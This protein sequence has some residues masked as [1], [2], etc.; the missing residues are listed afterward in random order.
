[1]L[2][3]GDVINI[4]ESVAP[5]TEAASWDNSGLLFG[6]LDKDINKILVT[7]DLTPEVADE[8]IDLGVDLIIEHHPSLFKGIKKFETN[9]VE[10]LAF[11][12]VAGR[13][14]CVYASHTASDFALLGLNNY[15]GEK[16]GFQ[17][18]KRVQ[19]GDNILFT[20]NIAT[21][22][23]CELK[24]ELADKFDDKY[25]YY[26]GNKDKKIN[27][28]AY[29]TGGGASVEE[30]SFAKECGADVYIS[31]DIKYHALRWTKD[32]GYAIINVNHYSSEI[33][34]VDYIADM[35]KNTNLEVI[36]S[37]CCTN[38]RN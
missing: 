5:L 24:D 1:M 33:I 13:G 14:I 36:K 18:I 27:K 31:G 6:N 20:A 28:V 25:A 26:V 37:K 19:C 22:S 23:L 12:K 34:F 9:D 2:K 32:S 38:P 16:A 21:K 11:L 17:D 3:L 10:E 8:A 35:F 29:L 7:L 4:I 15:F 30:I